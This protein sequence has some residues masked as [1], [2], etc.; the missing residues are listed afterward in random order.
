MEKTQIKKQNI[1]KILNKIII[2]SV[3]ISI[4]VIAIMIGVNYI[5]QS[6]LNLSKIGHNIN[7]LLFSATSSFILNMI[8]IY[9]ITMSIKKDKHIIINPLYATI[10]T[11][12]LN[13]LFIATTSIFFMFSNPKESLLENIANNSITALSLTFF[14]IV[15]LAIYQL[16]KDYDGPITEALLIVLNTIMGT[17]MTTQRFGAI[18]HLAESQKFT[19]SNILM[20][21]FSGIYLIMS[22]LSVIILIVAIISS[23]FDLDDEN[24]Y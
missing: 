15:G 12:F 19:A 22:F 24:T 5:K 23:I 4:A 9:Q 3:I 20:T 7:L 2:I 16:T 18:N 10:T 14:A 6:D 13:I 1:N 21:I 8:L 11:L 17:I